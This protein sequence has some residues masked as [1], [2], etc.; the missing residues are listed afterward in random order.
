MIQQ[1]K[2]LIMIMALP[3][4]LVACGGS[5]GGGGGGV[6][7]DNSKASGTYS[8]VVIEGSKAEVGSIT[9]DGAGGG[10]VT[11]ISPTPDGPNPITYTSYAD[12]SISLDTMVG[13][14]REG[15]NF[16]VLSNTNTGSEALIFAVKNSATPISDT[17]NSYRFAQFGH[18][19]SN[20]EIVLVDVDS[21]GAG[22]MNWSTIAPAP[23]VKGIDTYTFDNNSSGTYIITAGGG[24]LDDAYGAVSPDG[25]L[26]IYGDGIDFAADTFIYGGLGLEFPSSGM[27]VADL[28]GTYIM[29]QFMDDSVASG[30]SF[31]ASRFRVVSNGDGTGTYASIASSTGGSSSGP[32]TYTVSG[33]GSMTVFG[34]EGFL[35]ADGSV[36]VFVDHDTSGDDIDIKVAVRQ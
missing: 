31:I 5:S 24:G 33:D 6:A 16:I 8:F 23:N 28:S 29:H 36:Y 22:L 11:D 2:T 30:G 34:Q 3:L 7:V 15:G 27:T 14:I 1:I 35:L 20:S 4:A 17:A 13:T 10:T 19:G 32:L 9:F 18:D 21:D 26:Y 25:Q 12:N